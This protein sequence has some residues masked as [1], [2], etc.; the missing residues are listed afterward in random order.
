MAFCIVKQFLYRLTLF[1]ACERFPVFIGN[2]DFRF[3]EYLI[4]FPS[5]TSCICCHQSIEYNCKFAGNLSCA[6]LQIT[7]SSKMKFLV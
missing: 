1:E 4:I 6:F 7:R 5:L 2:E 3:H